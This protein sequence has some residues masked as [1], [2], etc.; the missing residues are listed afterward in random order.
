MDCK[1]QG[2]K[3]YGDIT[4]GDCWGVDR[5]DSTLNHKYGVSAI[6]VNNE[7][8]Q[9]LVDAIDKANIGTLKI[10]SL[11]DVKKIQCFGIFGQKRM[12]IFFEKK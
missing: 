8:G 11:A 3:R 6:I 12:E 7:K 4:I 9:D 5:F 10:I 1:Y 2:N